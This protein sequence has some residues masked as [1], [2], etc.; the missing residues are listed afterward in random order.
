[1][2]MPKCL[3]IRILATFA[4]PRIALLVSLILA[5]SLLH[6]ASLILVFHAAMI[7]ECMVGQKLLPM[8]LRHVMDGM[9]Q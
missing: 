9:V 3:S 7:K 5:N 2:R 6:L 1:M 8:S 4:T